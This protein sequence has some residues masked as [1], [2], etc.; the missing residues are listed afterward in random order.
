MWW[1]RWWKQKIRSS[2]SNSGD[3]LLIRHSWHNS[4]KAICFSLVLPVS[5]TSL[6]LVYRF[7]YQPSAGSAQAATL[8]HSQ[9]YPQSSHWG[10]GGSAL[11][12]TAPRA[13]GWQPGWFEALNPFHSTSLGEGY[14]SPFILRTIFLFCHDHQ[15]HNTFH[16][17]VGYLFISRRSENPNPL[18]QGAG[19]TSAA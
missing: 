6:G 3:F 13:W 18:F 16:V 19:C 17:I 10:G 14:K 9:I 11:S 15:C 7:L 4:S 2:L 12:P 5:P 1:F 8:L